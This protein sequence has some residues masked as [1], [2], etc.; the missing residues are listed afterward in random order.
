MSQSIQVILPKL[1]EA[2]GWTQLELARKS[3]VSNATISDIECGKKI[4]N[5]TTLQKIANAFNLEMSDLLSYQV[6]I[7]NESENDTDNNKCINLLTAKQREALKWANNI[8]NID[9]VV[10]IFELSKKVPKNLLNT[11]KYLIDLNS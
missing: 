7:N 6:N 9:Y 8:D 11:L 2:K 1:R 3:G 4:P 5:L 10:Y